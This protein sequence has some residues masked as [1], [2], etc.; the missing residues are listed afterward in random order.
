MAEHIFEDFM[1]T[2]VNRKMLNVHQEV[3]RT[4]VPI[5]FDGVDRVTVVN[6]GEVHTSDFIDTRRFKEIDIF[7]KNVINT[8]EPTRISFHSIFEANA[9]TNVSFYDWNTEKWE[10]GGSEN[11]S[12][13]LPYGAESRIYALSTHPDFYW[14]KN[15]KGRGL[16]LRFE[17]MG[18]PF[19]AG[20]SY[21]KAW[22][23]G[24]PND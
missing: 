22:L 6:E 1:T 14:V 20:T 13:Y 21:F 8:P 9:L 16:S 5:R 15:F 19:E 24:V 12:M 11:G 17:T 4:I 3:N 18:K 23:A 10:R 7:V 2:E